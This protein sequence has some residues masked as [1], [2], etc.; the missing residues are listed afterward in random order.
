MT[1][2]SKRRTKQYDVFWYVHNAAMPLWLGLLFIHGSN[3]WFSKG[4]PL[5]GIPAGL[6][7]VIPFC[8]LPVM[9]YLVDRVLRLMRYYLFA[10]Q[11]VKLVGA[12]IRPGKSGF[13]LD[14]LT[15]IMVS[16]PPFLWTKKD[17]MPGMYGL[18]CMPHYAPFQ[19]HP[20][21]ICSA[22]E[23]DTV[24]FIISGLGDWTQHLA[25]Q[26]LS[27]YAG[28]GELPKIALDGPYL[29]PT[30]AA[31]SKEVLVCVGAGVGITPFLSLLSTMITSLTKAIPHELAVKQAH[32]YWITRSAD[33]FLFARKQFTQLMRDATLQNKLVL[34]LHLTA[35][36]PKDDVAAFLFRNAVKRQSDLD[37]R[38]FSAVS[39][40]VDLTAVPPFMPYSWIGKS[41]CVDNDVIWLSS[42]VDPGAD[43][44]WECDDED[45]NIP[46][47]A[48]SDS[49][50]VHT[51]ETSKPAALRASG[52]TSTFDQLEELAESHKSHWSHGFFRSPATSKQL[53]QSMLSSKAS[54]ESTQT[55]HP[56]QIANVQDQLLPVVFGRPNFQEEI[57][58]IGLSWPEDNVD[59]FVCGNKALVASLQAV[60]ERCNA[61]SAS[62]STKTGI[63]VQ[64]YHLS[65]ERFG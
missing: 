8:S 60:C 49:G 50:A 22:K 42:L 32:F 64:R 37:R 19:W 6:P 45:I 11:S 48:E 40:S 5:L 26:C 51:L 7:L 56:K 13:A 53:S 3:S 27:A 63:P 14:S 44:N 12:V 43:E 55:C 31:L 59:V 54:L 57:R 35:P 38:V 29:A 33:E 28:E 61:E 39:Q 24:D 17:F 25:Q 41:S 36:T 21:T 1:S 65:F 9:C 52:T 34:H 23:D 2:S 16:K 30:S 18:L 62:S 15:Y 58:K 10:G 47:M 4:F 20:F 46:V